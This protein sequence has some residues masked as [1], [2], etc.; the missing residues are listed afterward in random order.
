MQLTGGK[1]RQ[2]R[3]NVNE[4]QQPTTDN[5]QPTAGKQCNACRGY[6]IW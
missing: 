4:N 6:C 5:R 3:N 2:L 1:W